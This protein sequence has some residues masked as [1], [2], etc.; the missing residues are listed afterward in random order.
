M[1]TPA[2]PVA[3]AQATSTGGAA[4][5]GRAPAGF[6][7]L[8]P[9][10]LSRHHVAQ[11]AGVMGDKIE[12][13]AMRQ[14]LDRRPMPQHGCP[15]DCRVAPLRLGAMF[16]HDGEALG[17]PQCR[18]DRGN[19]PPD[20]WRFRLTPASSTAQ[21]TLV[22]RGDHGPR[23]RLEPI[24]ITDASG[25]RIGATTPVIRPARPMTASRAKIAK[26]QNSPEGRTQASKTVP[27]GLG[28][29]HMPRLRRG[30]ATT[31][32]ARDPTSHYACAGPTC[33]GTMTR[34]HAAAALTASPGCV[35]SSPA[36]RKCAAG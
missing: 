9:F 24:V 20:P 30:P 10:A 19:C 18:E 22:P 21:Q 13:C 32:R 4:R 34:R 26:P 5:A 14:R 23:S 33:H 16:Q 6:F 28:R 7:A 12:V 25:Y 31:C 27:A 2:V 35:P 1:R 11:T 8:Q 17:P 15:H 29:R 36:G 3:S